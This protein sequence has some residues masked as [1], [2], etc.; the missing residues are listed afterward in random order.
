MLRPG[1]YG[2]NHIG[3]G[4]QNKNNNG[5]Q[6]NHMSEASKDDYAGIARLFDAVQL[7]SYFINYLYFITGTEVLIFV[8]TFFS[9]LRPENGPFPWKFYFYLSFIVPIAMTFLLGVF[10]LAFNKYVYGKNPASETDFES[11]S[12][13]ASV[14]NTVKTRLFINSMRTIP[15][16]PVLFFIVLGSVIF[17]KLDVIFLFV[18][19]A[20]EKAVKYSLMAVGILLVA[21]A[22]IGVVWIIVNYKLRKQHLENQHQYKNEVMNNLGLLI[23]DN[24]IIDKNGRIISDGHTSLLEMNKTDKERFQFL[25]P[26]Q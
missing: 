2:C 18:A 8:F 13:T 6:G 15:F 17:Y 12:D 19:N 9:H 26:P 22:V 4:I 5:Y 1:L 11:S 23:L 10:I 16:L 20:G 7:K 14:E 21:G 3:P 25:P 24:K